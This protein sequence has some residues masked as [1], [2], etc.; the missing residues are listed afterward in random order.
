MAYRPWFISYPQ[1][2]G[3]EHAARAPA[4]PAGDRC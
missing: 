3:A 1:E 4:R 2:I